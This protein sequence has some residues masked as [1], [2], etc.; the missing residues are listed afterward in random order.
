MNFFKP[1]VISFLLLT[2]CQ[3]S[4]DFQFQLRSDFIGTWMSETEDMVYEES[5]SW[6]DS[7]LNGQGLIYNNTDTLFTEK[8]QIVKKLGHW[9]YGATIAD[10]NDGETVR[11]KLQKPCTGPYIF[12]NKKHDFPQTISY[13]FGVDSAFIRIEGIENGVFKSDDLKLV[14]ATMRV[15]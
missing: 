9:Y 6:N 3:M 11:F 8:L 4:R 15:P 5:W 7:L 2:G 12:Q 14:K 10:Q 13:T 1:L